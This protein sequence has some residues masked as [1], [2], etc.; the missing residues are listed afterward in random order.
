MRRCH[1]ATGHSNE[2]NVLVGVLRK[3]EKVRKFEKGR[4]MRRTLAAMAARLPSWRHGF[5]QT[6]EQ[7]V[8]G[9]ACQ[10]ALS[11]TDFSNRNSVT[12]KL[13]MVFLLSLGC[14]GGRAAHRQ[15]VC[16][17]GSL[18]IRLD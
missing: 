1:T 6:R 5:F 11:H 13:P 8:S 2:A 3:E 17:N 9:V 14:E 15:D 18:L 4:E 12:P 7:A 16:A 10:G